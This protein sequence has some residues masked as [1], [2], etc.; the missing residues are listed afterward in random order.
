MRC[1]NIFET[2]LATGCKEQ[3]LKR[4]FDETVIG[5]ITING[6]ILKILDA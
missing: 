1:E 3:V 2:I 6:L 4:V 5:K